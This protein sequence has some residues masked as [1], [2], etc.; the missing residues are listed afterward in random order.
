MHCQH[1]D[2]SYNID[3]ILTVKISVKDN[4]LTWEVTDIQA[5]KDSQAIASIDVPS[6][7]LLSVDAAEEGANFAGAQV[8]TTTTS[9]GD[10]FIDFANGFVPSN[11]DGYLY[12][13]LQNGKLSAGL[14]SNSEAEG[15]KRVIR[16]NGADTI[17]LTSAPWYY[18]KETRTDKINHHNMIRIQRVNFH[19]QK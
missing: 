9:S 13:F 10:V 16:A 4:T 8:S 14:F 19:M 3:V 6:L 12:A 7:S 2:D 18:E 17:T 15:D 1:T 11:R 5:E